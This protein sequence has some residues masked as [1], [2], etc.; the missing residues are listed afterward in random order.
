MHR[1]PA[2]RANRRRLGRA[3]DELRGERRQAPPDGDRRPAGEP[4][5]R[6]RRLPRLDP[7]VRGSRPVAGVG[8]VSVREPI[9]DGPTE[10]EFR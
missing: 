6:A 3:H 4:Q 10:R 8:P 2:G 1:T 9:R 5:G 7:R